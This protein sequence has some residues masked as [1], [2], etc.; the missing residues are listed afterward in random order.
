MELAKKFKK[1]FTLV[2]L[3]VV[4]AIIAILA[5][6]SVAGYFGFINQANQSAADQEAAQVKTVLTYTVTKETVGLEFS[7]LP[8]SAEVQAEILAGIYLSGSG[9]SI[10]HGSALVAGEATIVVTTAAKT[11]TECTYYSAKGISSKITF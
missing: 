7:T 1:G 2:E 5:S 8:A 3:I 10:E 11:L 9:A 6:V 4:I